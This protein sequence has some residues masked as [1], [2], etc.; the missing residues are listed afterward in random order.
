MY[1]AADDPYCYPG[2]SVLK[3]RLDLRSQAELDAFEAMITTQRADEP[4]PAGELDDEHYRAIH[5]HLFQD[6]FDWAGEIR[7]VRLTKG[8]STFC[9]PEN[10]AAQMRGLFA[11]LAA[12]NHYRDLDAEAFA[13]R[14]LMSWRSSMQF[15]PFG[16][17][18]AGRRTCFCRS[19]LIVPVI[20]SI[21]NSSTPP[22]DG[23]HDCELR[24]GDWPLAN[25]SCDYTGPL[26]PRHRAAQAG[27]AEIIP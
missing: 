4:L 27:D 9:F 16:K 8:A 10:I 15:I 3:N 14:L 25:W 5:R 24:P 6:V 19:W 11:K 17:G 2:T 7:S 13:S 26:T 12:D 20:R 22:T 1:E 18:M 23:G 21:S